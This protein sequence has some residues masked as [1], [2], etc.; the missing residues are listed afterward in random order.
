MDFS[1]TEGTMNIMKIIIAREL[2]GKEFL[3]YR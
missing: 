1:W 2:L 3:P